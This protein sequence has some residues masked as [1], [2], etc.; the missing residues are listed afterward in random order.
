MAIAGFLA[1]AAATSGDG[2]RQHHVEGGEAEHFC[3]VP[4]AGRYLQTV[5]LAHRATRGGHEGTKSCR[6]NER[7]LFEVK[8]DS[9]GKACL[10][11]SQC[12]LQARA[13]GQIKL[14]LDSNDIGIA[15][16][17]CADRK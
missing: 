7:Q 11:L 4:P 10:G 2:K 3:H 1:A 16:L 13:V 5:V 12:M 9:D 17:R 8:Q 15:F 14:T 6:V